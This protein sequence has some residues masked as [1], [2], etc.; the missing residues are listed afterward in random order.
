MSAFHRPQRIRSACSPLALAAGLMLATLPLAQA[1]APTTPAPA[2]ASAAAARPAA[3][4]GKAPAAAAA[5]PA[6]DVVL[7]SPAAAPAAV[8]GGRLV[9]TPAGAGSS[10]Y[11]TPLHDGATAGA[12]ADLGL[13]LLRQQSQAS[14]Q[15]QRNQLV[16][17][18]SVASA[19]GLVHAGSAGATASEV[20]RLLSPAAAGDSFFRERLPSH[21]Q[22]LAER[23][24][25]ALSM[26]SRVW[27]DRALIGEVPASFAAL[28]SQRLRADGAV[29]SF[30]QPE[31]ARG[32]INSWAAAGTG[33]RIPALL[34]P[35]S[36][37]P[38]TRVVITNAIHFRSRWDK[39]FDSSRT[40][41]LPFTLGNGTVKP[42]PTMVDDRPARHGTVAGMQVLELPFAGNEFALVLAM[43][44]VGHSLDAA[45]KAVSGLDMA[46]WSGQLQASSCRVQLPRFSVQ[47][48]AEALRPA[49]QDLG[50]RTAF[51]PGADLSPLLGQAARGVSLA[52]VFHAATIEIDE[53]GGVATAA[54]AATAEFKSLALPSSACKVDRPF[55]FTIVHKAT[56]TPL[57]VGKVAEPV[58]P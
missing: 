17:P 44:P 45:E 50:M 32:A 19:L 39:P 56:Q 53:T 29:T 38:N 31:A 26:A 57:F 55:L 51:G 10:L 25:G 54:T 2:A 58:S 36:L 40:T 11:T 9:P 5:T 28:A 14:G 41:A 43:A 20:A 37:T 23:G 33:G 47:G 4:E 52:Q 3:S 6:K 22:R 12:L 27:V 48:G 34:P 24:S 49:L 35:G 8:Q 18:L 21:V 13:A 15:A 46:A 42:V 1:Q 7:D 16:S 30:A